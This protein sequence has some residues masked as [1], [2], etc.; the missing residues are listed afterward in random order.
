VGG[1]PVAARPKGMW[2]RRFSNL[3]N[4]S[5][6]ADIVADMHFDARLMALVERVAARG[7]DVVDEVAARNAPVKSL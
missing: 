6:V 5:V 3:Q 1:T 2:R 7:G 4:A